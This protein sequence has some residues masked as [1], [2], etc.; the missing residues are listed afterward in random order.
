MACGTQNPVSL[1]EARNALL[2]GDCRAAQ[3]Q[4]EQILIADNRNSAALH[5]LA[6]I[7][8]LEGRHAEAAASLERAL[9]MNP[10]QASWHTDLGTIYRATEDWSQAA[11]HFANACGLCPD[12]LR[13]QI[14]YGRALL[15]LGCHERSAVHFQ[16]AM[17]LEPGSVAAALGLADALARQQQF[18]EAA[19]LLE[20][21]LKSNPGHAAIH[22]ALG[23]IYSGCGEN[24][25]ARAHWEAVL[26]TTPGDTEAH[27]ALVSVCWSLGDV[28]ATLAH[29]RVLIDS[30]QATIALHSFFLY[31]LLFSDGQTPGSIKESC[32]QFGRR[33]QPIRENRWVPKSNEDPRRR[34]RV[35]YLTGEFTSGAAFY[36]LSPLFAYHDPT[37][38]DVFCYHTR[39]QLDRRTQ[40]YQ[41]AGHW[42][43][44]RDLD[45]AA[46]K[47][48]LHRDHIDILVDL[49]GFF[50]EHRLWIF[51]E[52]A[53]P[54]QV[55]YPNCPTTTGVPQI[56]YILTDRWTCPPGHESYYTEEAVRLPSGYLVY[57]P[58][59]IAPPVKSLPA[60][61]DGV[62][63]FGLFQRR[64][65]MNA[66]V[67]DSIAELLRRCPKSQ[68]LIQ[69][70]DPTLDEPDSSTRREL[71]T[72]FAGRGIAC[73]R[74]RLLGARPH[75]ETLALMGEVDIALDTFPYQ[76]QTTTCECLWMGV[77]VVAL[78]GDAHVARVGTAILQRA[79]LGGL[80]AKS[81]EEYIRIALELANDREELFRLRTGMRDRMRQS[82][83][84][85]GKGLARSVE[86][87][88]RAMWGRWCAGAKALA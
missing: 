46:L 77:P 71:M 15:E 8:A 68:L 12:D 26:E 31:V 54:I 4:T 6:L 24:D 78:S 28:E 13:A 35:G 60:S 40:W 55:T 70:M 63:T 57:S 20:Q 14:G 21:T 59:E 50:P 7:Q 38:V 49:S 25:C 39:P 75:P 43:D 73:D 64:A 33:I 41:R 65:K 5:L 88:Y 79:G 84:M 2:R 61:Q 53:A 3:E 51:A 62:I 18:D 23:E 58:P 81:R 82:S 16:H 52:R 44:C 34:L 85:D 83:I 32:E 74:L 37:E 22:R 42:R 29:G 72:A 30:G 66:G 45:D 80:T 17:R 69:N 11:I 48:Q 36:F 1:A 10:N 27:A 76:G 87:A 67:W 56:D 9:E 19:G 47:E 86:A